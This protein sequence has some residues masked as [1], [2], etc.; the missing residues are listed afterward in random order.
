MDLKSIVVTTLQ[1]RWNHSKLN[2]LILPSPNNT[3]IESI[4][5][6][7][8]D[9]VNKVQEWLDAN[10]TATLEEIKYQKEEFEAFIKPILEQAQQAFAGSQAG[11]QA[12]SSD[13]GPSDTED[14]KPT[15]EEVD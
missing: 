1:A 2:S 10:Q 15:I 7:I 6:Q 9:K 11:D 14:N 3:R 8:V 13:Q 4:K 12:G 5:T